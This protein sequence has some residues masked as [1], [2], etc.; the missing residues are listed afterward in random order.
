MQAQARR[1]GWALLLVGIWSTSACD[2]VGKPGEDGADG[3]DGLPGEDGAAGADGEDGPTGPDGATGEDGHSASNFDSDGDGVLAADDCDDLDATVGAAPTLY[4]DFDGDG[5][6]DPAITNITCFS[7]AGWVA[8]GTDCNDLDATVSPAATEVCNSGQD[9]D[10][11]GLSDD[12]DPSVDLSTGSEFYVDADGDGY[13]DDTAL[14]AAA[15][16]CDDG[17]STVNPDAEEVCDNGVDDNCNGSL[18]SCGFTGTYTLESDEDVLMLGAGTYDDF[19]R[20]LATGD[21]NGDGIDDLIVG[22]SGYDDSASG[23]GAAY[24]FLGTTSTADLGTYDTLVEGGDSNDNLGADVVAIDLDDD[25]YDDVII[26]AP[27]TDATYV[28]FGSV[29]GLNASTTAGAA[30]VLLEDT[31]SSAAFGYDVGSAGDVDGDGIDDLLVGT[32]SSSSSVISSVYLVVGTTSWSTSLDLSSGGYTARI[33]TNSGDRGDGLASRDAAAGA[34]FDGDGISDVALGE[35]SNDDNGTAYG[36]VYLFSGTAMSGDLEADDADTRIVTSSMTSSGKLGE[37][38]DVASDY[39]GD[40]LPDLLVGANDHAG[41]SATSAGRAFVYFGATSGWGSSVDYANA[42]VF[43]DGAAA[44]DDFGISVNGIN[45]LDGDGLGDVAVGATGWDGEL[46]S[47]SSM[48]GSWVFASQAGST[49]GVFLA[50]D[51]LF[52]VDGSS[53][54]NELGEELVT[55]DYNGDGTPDFA[56]GA[57]SGAG[58]Y[59]SVG[60]FFGTGL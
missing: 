5:Y 9:D 60:I 2:R 13:G 15:G 43:F 29:T 28:F 23:A 16:D 7:P 21:V 46:S 39:N 41:L 8:E 47:D 36:A 4:L 37:S 40:G 48:G 59:G 17:D 50:T 1:A 34:D 56:V 49:G 44:Y 38:V 55:G 3:A 52:R 27:G 42:D 25:G 22:E 45:D 14:T 51:A 54:S 18:D 31:S 32:Y 53:S 35:Y 57:M 58:Y 20:D 33:D 6:G 30:D 12:A 24:V 26:G 11:D 10:C 19:G